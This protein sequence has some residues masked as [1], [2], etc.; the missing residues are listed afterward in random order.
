[1]RFRGCSVKLGGFALRSGSH[2]GEHSL[3][4]SSGL[5]S[6]GAEKHFARPACLCALRAGHVDQD[7]DLTQLSFE[8]FGIVF[9]KTESDQSLRTAAQRSSIFGD[10]ERVKKCL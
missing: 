5:T 1:M 10:Y 8:S 7:S 6:S 3:F 4:Q 9:G 2:S